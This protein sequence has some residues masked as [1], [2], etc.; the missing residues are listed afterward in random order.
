MKKICAIYTRKSTDERLDM[1]FN[2]LDAQRESCEAY[3]TSQRSEGWLASREKYDDGGFSGGSLERPA[4]KRLLEDIR[5]GKVHTIVVYKIDRLTRSLMDFAKLVQVFDEHGVTFVSV[6]QSFNTTTSMGRLTLNVLLSFAQFEREVSGERIRDKITASKARGMWMGGVPPVGYKIEHRQLVVNMDEAK[7]ARYIF[8]HYLALE[9]VRSLKEELDRKGVKSPERKSLAGKPYG[10]SNFSRGALYA[11]LKN[12]AYIGKISHKGKIHEGLHEGII[13][14]D[15]W[16]NVQLKMK[17]QRV[18][19]TAHTKRRH[20]L[21]GLLYDTEGALYSPTFTSRHDRQYCYYIS[22]NLTQNR[23][24]PHG[25]MS[26]LPA[27][28][29]ETLVEKTIR[30]TIEK[31]CEGMEDSVF[32]HI[33]EHQG[34]IPAHDLIRGCVDGITASLNELTIK[35][36]PAGFKDLVKRHLQV[37]IDEC[38][39]EYEVTVP[40]KVGKAKRG[41]IVIRPEGRDIFDLPP[42]D[43]KKLIQGVVWRDEHFEGMTLKDIARREGR[44]EGFIGQ[45]IFKSFDFGADNLLA[46]KNSS[47]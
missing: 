33:L 32:Q 47:Y 42:S 28:E 46:V 16:E 25:I 13:P 27:H 22:Q 12:P 6:T 36:K 34:A 17:D 37:N 8:D 10:G 35:L 20:M 23:N 9:N 26:R 7:L 4:L 11:I 3:I 38:K 43:L 21:Q 19:R 30:D 44:S 24:H 39:G 15:T 5:A 41:A 18:E 29:I 14:I 1:E 45:C 40:F 2:T 31:F